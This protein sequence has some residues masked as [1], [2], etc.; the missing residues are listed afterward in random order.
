[1]GEV[2]LRRYI[3]RRLAKLREAAELTQKQAA[4][5]TQ[6]GVST[7]ARMESGD[8]G[9]RFRD[10]D[11]N[12]FLDVYHADPDERQ[13]LLAYTAET[14]N[15]ARTKQWW[16]AYREDMPEWFALYV[17]LEDSARTIREYQSELIPGLL[18][19]REY[20]EKFTRTDGAL[21]D[22]VVERR[23]EIRLERQGLLQRDQAPHL[24]VILNEAAIRR[25]VGGPDVMTAQLE[26][27]LRMSD[28]DNITIRILPFSAGEH[29]GMGGPFIL[30]DFPVDA[31]GEQLEP[32]IAYVDT[33]T[34]SMYMSKP[35]EARDYDAV[36]NDLG[37]KAL[38]EAESRQLI[39]S[40]MEGFQ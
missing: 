3:G 11:V 4:L 34:G 26:H 8:L 17:I 5:A 25:P 32:P 31:N 21:D 10:V 40:T 37:A 30:L 24:H 1:M 18:Q 13:R 39:I 35:E 29:G 28:R 6:K 27:L 9:I 7:I 20:F 14:R 16:E 22:A 23:V 15:G 12:L 33:L 36:W 2:V 19:T 38:D